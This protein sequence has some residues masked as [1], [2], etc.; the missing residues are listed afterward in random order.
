MAAPALVALAHGSRDRRSAATIKALVGEVRAMR[1]DLKVEVIRGN[2]GTRLQK[3][4]DGI[5]EATLLAVAGLKRLEQADKITSY[6]DPLQLLPAPA[7]GAICVEIR[8]ADAR[9]ASLVQPLNHGE[10]A[11]ALVAERA[12]LTTLDGSCRTPIG[13]FTDLN[14]I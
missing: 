2:V 12:L 3:L 13:A 5:A 9:T 14:A 11:T 7:Q 1:P 4:E 10:T 6:L 8:A